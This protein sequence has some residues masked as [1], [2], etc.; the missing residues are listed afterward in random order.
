[1]MRTRGGGDCDD[2][3]PAV[4][5]GAE[6]CNDIDDDCDNEIDEGLIALAYR[7]ADGDGFGDSMDA[8]EACTLPLGMRRAARL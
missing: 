1:M 6:T 5:P 4:Y 7:D 8:I 2:S 3:D